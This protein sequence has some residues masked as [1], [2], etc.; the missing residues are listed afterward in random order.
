[1]N[2]DLM[3]KQWLPSFLEIGNFRI[4]ITMLTN[5]NKNCVYDKPDEILKSKVEK[6]CLLMLVK[7][8]KTLV[9]STFAAS[10]PDSDLIS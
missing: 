4:L 6:E 2:V 8:I 1:M 7:I 3:K 10:V 5:L 9:M